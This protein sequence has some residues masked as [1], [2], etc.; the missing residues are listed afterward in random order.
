MPWHATDVEPILCCPTLAI[1]GGQ[2]RRRI[3]QDLK[4]AP[5]TPMS[6]FDC[7]CVSAT[8]LGSTIST[9][10]KQHPYD[11]GM[12]FRCREMQGSA[13]IRMGQARVRSVRK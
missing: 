12:T 10:R 13:S 5:V 3:P 7:R 8:A 2:V 11:F 1:F 6:S 9:G 4:Y